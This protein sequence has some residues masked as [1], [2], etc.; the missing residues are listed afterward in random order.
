MAKELEVLFVDDEDSI[1]LT[2][3]MML[4]TFGFKVTAAG[5]LAEALRLISERKFDVLLS[6][7]NIQRPGDGF[8]VVSAMKSVQPNAVRLILTG[9]PDID[10]AVRAMRERGSRRRSQRPAS[11][12]LKLWSP[13][14]PRRPRASASLAE[15]ALG[16]VWAVEDELLVRPIV[17]PVGVPAFAD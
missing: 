15:L 2:L 16:T 8:T 12:C 5:T 13:S 9:Y 7:L 14:P 3:P 4:Q 10:T 17:N 6:D 1:R 11:R